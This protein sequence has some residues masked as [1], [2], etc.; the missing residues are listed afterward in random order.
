VRDLR[1]GR[2]ARWRTQPANRHTHDFFFERDY[3]DVKLLERI[4]GRLRAEP[5][6]QEFTEKQSGIPF[7][8]F[9]K[10]LEKL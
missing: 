5:R 1:D 10:A 3:P 9:E 4:Y 6:P 7:D 2:R 8:V